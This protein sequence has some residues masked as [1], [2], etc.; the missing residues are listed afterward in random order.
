ML[1]RVLWNRVNLRH[2]RCVYVMCMRVYSYLILA[3]WWQH[4]YRV[5]RC[6]CRR[7]MTG[8]R[9]HTRWKRYSGDS[10]SV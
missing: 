2:S 6:N 4:S 10:Q 5:R 7:N 1:H 9:S 8:I 3:E